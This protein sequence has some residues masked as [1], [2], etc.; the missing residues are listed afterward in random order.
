MLP[1][2]GCRSWQI[3]GPAGE[4]A[5]EGSRIFARAKH[6]HR[7]CSPSRPHTRRGP[8]ISTIRRFCCAKWTTQSHAMLFTQ[9]E[10]EAQGSSGGQKL[11]PQKGIYPRIVGGGGSEVGSG[12]G[13]KPVLDFLVDGTS[14]CVPSLIKIRARISEWETRAPAKKGW[15]RRVA[16]SLG[17][18]Q[19]M[20]ETCLCAAFRRCGTTPLQS[21]TGLSKMLPSLPLRNGEI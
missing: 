7:I 11:G 6:G 18:A 17:A 8:L 14:P 2:V 19:P 9:L 5:S 4:A 20:R 10:R 12:A 15:V 3:R 16:F 21:S 13:K 1:L